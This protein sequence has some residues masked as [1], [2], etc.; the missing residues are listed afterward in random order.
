MKKTVKRF[1][2]V[3]TKYVVDVHTK[4]VE[5]MS[6]KDI[7]YIKGSTDEYKK[8]SNSRVLKNIFKDA[9]DG[10]EVDLSKLSDYKFFVESKV[11]DESIDELLKIDAKIAELKAKREVY[12]SLLKAEAAL[13]YNQNGVCMPSIATDAGTVALTVAYSIVEEKP[14]ALKRILKDKDGDYV[15]RKVDYGLTSKAKSIIQNII[16]N[17]YDPSTT[18]EG[19]M[20]QLSVDHKSKKVLTIEEICSGLKKTI[21]ANKTYLQRIFDISDAAAYEAANRCMLI[22]NY[23]EIKNFMRTCDVDIDDEEA[24]KKFLDD[25][26]KTVTVRM[27]HR[28][29]TTPAALARN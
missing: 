21:D 16:S 12:D 17:N 13:Y 10:G 22:R 14:R 29:S 2:P 23:E 6:V 18:I 9:V 19:M 7:Y 24:C 20:A 26:L 5:G 4:L 27:S 11:S 8:L 28:L 3:T 15:V 1:I 25:V